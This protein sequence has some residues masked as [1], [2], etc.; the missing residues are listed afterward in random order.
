MDKS[1]IFAPFGPLGPLDRLESPE[2]VFLPRRSPFKFSWSSE[3][4]RLRSLLISDEFR[5]TGLTS[6]TCG[7][8]STARVMG[9]PLR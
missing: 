5:C 2:R 8:P 9:R 7:L 6:F 3:R 1:G 4:R